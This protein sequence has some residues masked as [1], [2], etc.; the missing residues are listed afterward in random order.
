MLAKWGRWPHLAEVLPARICLFDQG[1]LFFASPSFDLFF[2]GD[3]I[4]DVL[5]G[6]KPNQACALVIGAESFGLSFTVLFYSTLKVIGDTTIEDAAAARHYVN[7]VVMLSTHGRP[8]VPP[9]KQQVPP[10]RYAPVGMTIPWGT[11]GKTGLW[12]RIRG[13]KKTAG[14]SAP[15]RFGR[16]DNSVGGPAARQVCG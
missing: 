16:D 9:K 2:P 14:P 10:L 1:D 7:V 8:I 12:V 3:C 4:V 5:E 6:L 11:G 15:L 13:A